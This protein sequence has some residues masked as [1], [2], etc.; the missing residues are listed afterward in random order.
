[1]NPETRG[2]QAKERQT[3]KSQSQIQARNVDALVDQSLRN[4]NSHKRKR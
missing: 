2:R 4:G 3:Q 1:M